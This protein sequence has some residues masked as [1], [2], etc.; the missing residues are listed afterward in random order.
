MGVGG[1]IYIWVITFEPGGT[2][3]KKLRVLLKYR[4]NRV[5]PWKAF[6][7]RYIDLAGIIHPKKQFRPLQEGFRALCFLST[8]A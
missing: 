4:S 2:L 1:I 5:L 3:N 6:L 8:I 7:G